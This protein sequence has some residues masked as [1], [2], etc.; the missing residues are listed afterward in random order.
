MAQETHL[1]G[2]K[3]RAS[4]TILVFWPPREDPKSTKM[5]SKTSQNLRRF[6]RSKTLIF[7]SL[8]EPSW[9]DLGPFWKPSW[10]QKSSSRIGIR[11]ISCK[12]TFL[13]L[14]SFQDAIWSELGRTW[15]RK[16]SKMTT[17]R[18]PRRPKIACVHV[19]MNLASRFLHAHMHTAGL[20]GLLGGP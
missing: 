14:I 5:A 20:L 10:A 3:A 9:A 18:T 1:E 16:S 4:S 2:Q 6:S 15:P 13:M 8:L 19:R 7:K 12:I 17:S 11:S